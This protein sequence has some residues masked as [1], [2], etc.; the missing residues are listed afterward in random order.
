MEQGKGRLGG[1]KG[2]ERKGV[3]GKSKKAS[4][5]RIFFLKEIEIIFF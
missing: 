1:A 3:I 5:F 4:F 2:G